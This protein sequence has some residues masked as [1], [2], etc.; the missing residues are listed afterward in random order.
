[1]LLKWE[2]YC[3]LLDFMTLVALFA[4]QHPEPFFTMVICFICKTL[5]KY[6]S[7]QPSQ[8]S[9]ALAEFSHFYAGDKG[10]MTDVNINFHVF[11]CDW[12][13]GRGADRPRER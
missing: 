3:P 9:Q 4:Y 2:I 1:M 8:N 6:A 5:S 7:L 13:G 12:E 11:I 10:Q